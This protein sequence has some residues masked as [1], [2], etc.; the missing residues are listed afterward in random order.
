MIL[1]AETHL[2][3]TTKELFIFAI[4]KSFHSVIL[5]STNDL[6]KMGEVI[7]Y[8]RYSPLRIMRDRVFRTCFHFALAILKLIP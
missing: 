1:Q 7:F 5:Y 4:L 6:K 2:F 8:T 3:Q